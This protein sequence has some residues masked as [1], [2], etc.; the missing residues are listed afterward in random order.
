MGLH[1][2]LKEMKGKNLTFCRNNLLASGST[3]LFVFVCLFLF[4]WTPSQRKEVGIHIGIL[5]Q[6]R[7]QN[8]HS[9]FSRPGQS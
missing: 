2:A 4:E 1:E 5:H 8:K 9:Y 6:V 3:F 7:D